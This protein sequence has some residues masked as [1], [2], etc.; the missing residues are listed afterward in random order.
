MQ[1]AVIGA[2]HIIALVI[3]AGALAS[4]YFLFR[5]GMSTQDVEKV[6][7]ADF[8]HLLALA[9]LIITGI[10]RIHGFEQ[11]TSYYLHNELFLLKLVMVGTIFFLSIYPSI[12]FW[13]WRSAIR[14]NRASL[15]TRHQQQLIIWSIRIELFL[16]LIIPVLSS[17]VRHGFS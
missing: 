12:T 7:I 2:L 4:E 3:M 13:Y 15:I 1:E 16:L 5:R 6:L 8:L 11:S 10:I 9:S 14:N 17:L